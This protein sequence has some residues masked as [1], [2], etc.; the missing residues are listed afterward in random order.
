MLIENQIYQCLNSPVATTDAPDQYRVNIAEQLK[1]NLR[2]NT[3][4]IVQEN[5][6][7]AFSTSDMERLAIRYEFADGTEREWVSRALHATIKRHVT[8]D[9]LISDL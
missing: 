7:E 9:L 4:A 3:P 6:K 1:K 8:E 2:H 5:I